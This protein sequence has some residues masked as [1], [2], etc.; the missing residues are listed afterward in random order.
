MTGPGP[1]TCG[2]SRPGPPTRSSTNTKYSKDTNKYVS[3][4]G[5]DYFVG[6]CNNSESVEDENDDNVGENGTLHVEEGLNVSEDEDDVDLSYSDDNDDDKDRKKRRKDKS[7]SGNI[8]HLTKKCLYE[9]AKEDIAKGVY[10]S[11]ISGPHLC[12]S[13][14]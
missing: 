1:S 6:A 7:L 5:Y 10:K 8:E 13:G 14:S 9:A 4:E 12:V 3:G 2:V 11:Y